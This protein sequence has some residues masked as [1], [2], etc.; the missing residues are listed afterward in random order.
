MGL[1][2]PN[3]ITIGRILL[4]PLIVWLIVSDQALL[5]FIAFVIAGVSD[6]VDGFIAKRFSQTTELGAYLDPLADKLLLVSIYVSLGMQGALPAWLAILVVSRDVLIIG[7]LMLSWL[8][9]KPVE[10]VPLMV[11][12]ANTTVQIVLAAFVLG[13]HGFGIEAQDLINLLI[14]LVAVFTV[15]SAAAYMRVWVLHMANG[16][17]HVE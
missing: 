3:I 1:S 11:S 16:D 4:V 2:L 5:A 15:L 17:G 6:G 14:V 13:A 7:A 8:L 12:K 10:V 9:D